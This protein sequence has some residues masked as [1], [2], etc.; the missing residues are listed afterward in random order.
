M[1]TNS[2]DPGKYILPCESHEEVESV[3]CIL[4]GF[5]NYFDRTWEK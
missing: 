4:S 1:A 2:I 3:F 5:V